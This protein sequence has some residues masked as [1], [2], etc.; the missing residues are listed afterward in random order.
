MRQSPVVVVAAVVSSLIAMWSVSVRSQASQIDFAIDQAPASGEAR[1]AEPA[2]GAVSFDCGD[3]FY[4]DGMAENSIFFGGG[5]AG[6]TDHFLGVRFE[7]DDFGLEPRRVLLTGFCISNSLDLSSFGGPWSNEVFVYRDLD[8]EPA[9][10]DPQRQATVM[11]GDGTGPVEVVF[12]EPWLVDEPVFWLMTQGFPEHAGE[13]FNMESDQDSE[14]AG[15][16][17]IADRGVAFMIPTEQNF[18]L[19]AAVEVLP[20]AAMAV[21]ALGGRALLL[22]VALIAVVVLLRRRVDAR[23]G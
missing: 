20:G 13:D 7:L 10:D 18:M 11:T 8:G 1:L 9:L 23:R 4:D 21:P 16:S 3:L 6:E 14:A 17:W 15:R 19:R 2:R 22:L 5:Q 12:D